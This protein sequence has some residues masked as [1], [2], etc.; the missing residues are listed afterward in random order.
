MSD[1]EVEKPLYSLIQFPEG[2]D[3]TDYY[4]QVRIGMCMAHVQDSLL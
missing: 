2:V 1:T 3:I 4:V